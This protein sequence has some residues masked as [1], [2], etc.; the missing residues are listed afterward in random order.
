MGFTSLFTKNDKQ[1]EKFWEFK[2]F[3][4]KLID[5][6]IYHKNIQKSIFDNDENYSKEIL[7]QIIQKYKFIDLFEYW[8]L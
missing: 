2:N 5:L 4:Y 1:N 7:P 6:I 3:C 8:R